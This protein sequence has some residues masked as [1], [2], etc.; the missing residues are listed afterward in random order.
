MA[1]PI[2]TREI[3]TGPGPLAKALK[4]KLTPTDYIRFVWLV[5]IG[6]VGL[7]GLSLLTN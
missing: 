6:V 1:R 2:E 7:A 4:E 5:G 3:N